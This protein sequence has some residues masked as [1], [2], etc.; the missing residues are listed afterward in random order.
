MKINKPL[1]IVFLVLLAASCGKKPT[2]NSASTS[3][4]SDTT[5]D[6]STTSEV[7][8]L[9]ENLNVYFLEMNDCYGDSFIVKYH[10]FEI[11]VDGG[12]QADSV[13]VRQALKKYCTDGVLDMLIV[14]HPH[15][16]HTGGIA[17]RNTFREISSIGTVV[18]YGYQYSTSW[19]TGYE[20][21]R[22][23]YIELGATYYPI[24][25][26][27]NDESINPIFDIAEDLSIEFLDTGL[28][29]PPE[30]KKDSKEIDDDKFNEYISRY[31]FKMPEN[32]RI[33]ME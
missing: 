26:I 2:S 10:D 14:S 9:S 18:D 21:N 22:N 15:N 13:C 31:D 27:F 20:S 3:I 28:Y 5:T 30:E 19:N 12:T 16:D 33:I 8:D 29:L 1:S 25:N 7:V 11:L 32:Y 17:D 24:Y 6:T 23:K 4:N